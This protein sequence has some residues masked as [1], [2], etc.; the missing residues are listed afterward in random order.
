MVENVAHTIKMNQNQHTSPSPCGEMNAQQ[1][2][3][4]GK[5]SPKK[6]LLNT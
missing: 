1:F 6:Q 4:K 3:L 2:I 5:S